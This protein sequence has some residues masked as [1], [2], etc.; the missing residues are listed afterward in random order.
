MPV[1]FV[2]VTDVRIPSGDVTKI[3]ET[4][5]GRVLWEK[6]PQKTATSLRMSGIP[7]TMATVGNSTSLTFIVQYSDGSSEGT[8]DVTLSSNSSALRVNGLTITAVGTGAVTLTA[9]HGASGLTAS[10]SWVI[11]G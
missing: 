2:N 10:Q 1:E 8:T 3:T 6:K 11:T 4:N 7:N 9:R 5:T